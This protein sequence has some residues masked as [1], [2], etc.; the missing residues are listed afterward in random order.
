MNTALD[1]A[2][3]AAR[4]WIDGL[5]ERSVA[6]TA[7]LMDLKR[8][9][10]GP[11]PYEG[12][13]A[14]E[15]V[16]ALARDAGPGMHGSAGG[17]FFAW[18]IGGGL[19]SALAADWLVTTWD[20]NATVYASSPASAVIEETAG[21]WIKELLDL[22]RDASFAFTSGCQMAHMTSLAAA[23]AAL[24]GRVGWNME[25]DGLI[26]APGIRVLTS[27][28]RHV[29]VDRAVRFLGIGRQAID[30]LKTDGDGR[31]SPAVLDGALSDS[32][33]PT[34][35]VLNAADLNIGACDAFRELISMAHSAGAWVHIDGAFGLF[36]RASR[37]YRHLLDGVELA[38]SWATDGHKWLNVPFDCGIAIIADREA[39]RTAMTS[40][41]SYVAPTTIAR[42]QSDWNPEYSRRARGVPAYAALKQLGRSGMEALVDRCCAHCAN[43]V[44]GI[45]E[46]PGAEILARPTLNQGLL[47]F[48]RPGASPAENDAFTDET[49]QKINAT[50][51]AF[52]SGTTWRNLRAM[53]VSVVNWRTSEQDV[54]RAI[55]AATSVLT[56]EVAVPIGLEVAPLA[57]T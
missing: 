46:L 4:A 10:A 15:V 12:S 3:R 50:G 9:F 39:H 42:D 5:D 25:E 8:S 26:G 22:P 56:P 20:Q 35:L 47:R 45:G 11:L 53:R 29:T 33:K 40:S 6:A 48:A 43:I 27:D 38:D 44:E 13:S 34:M 14:E 16:Q 2:Y 51:E 49:I 23:R 57:N 52:F 37:T 24:L 54:K 36:A 41:A 55:A 7:S 18:V 17:R 19:E 30:Q 32:S 31:V 1:L 28:Q 21:E